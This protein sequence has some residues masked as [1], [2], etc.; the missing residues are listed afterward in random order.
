[1]ETFTIRDLRNRTGDLIREAEQGHLSLI[2]KHGQPVFV[3]V[4]FDEVLLQSGVRVSMAIHLFA[5]NKV[6][7]VQA[8]RL[9][10]LSPS[11]MMDKLAEQKVPIVNYTK[12]ELVNELEQFNQ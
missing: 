1:M 2:T 11:E 10:G 5:E 3:A 12:D 4:P 8:A 9:A 6:S 7:L